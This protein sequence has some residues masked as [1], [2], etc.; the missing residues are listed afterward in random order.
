M[1]GG[2]DNTGKAVQEGV[3]QGYGSSVPE[4]QDRWPTR[5]LQSTVEI[6]FESER[7]RSSFSMWQVALGWG[8]GN[9]MMWFMLEKMTSHCVEKTG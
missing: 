2:G 5:D 6:R 4:G 7:M 8:T 3:G 9:G 1:W